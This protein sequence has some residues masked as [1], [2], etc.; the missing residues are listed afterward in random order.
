MPQARRS[1]YGATRTTVDGF[2]FDSKAEARY[3]RYLL[4]VS[5]LGNL[6]DLE[7]QPFWDLHVCGVK[8]GRYIADF[9]HKY[10]LGGIWWDVITDVKGFDTPLSRWKRRHAEAEY[11]IQIEVIR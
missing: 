5:T 4:T 3:Y 1:K 2:T 7:L 9:R 11:G 6:R 10:L 8:I